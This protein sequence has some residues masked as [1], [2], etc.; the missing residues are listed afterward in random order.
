MKTPDEF[1]NEFIEKTGRDNEDKCSGDLTFESQG[2]QND[3]KVTLI[4]SGKKTAFFSALSSFLIDSEPLPLSGELYMVFDRSNTPVCIIEIDSVE[5]VP[6]CEVTW[7]M[8]QKEGED[9]SLNEWK[10]KQ[11]ENLEDEGNILGFSFS[12]DLKLVYQTFRVV[13]TNF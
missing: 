3:S 7:E 13:Y 8:A 5:I 12:E 1:W 4:L 10:E 11:K 2:F 9:S 6:F